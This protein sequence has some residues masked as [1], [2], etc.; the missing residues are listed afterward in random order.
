VKREKLIINRL[1]SEIYNEIQSTLNVSHFTFHTSLF[2]IL[3][4][5]YSG[6][7]AENSND[8][9]QKFL[10][11][12]ESMEATFIQS[13]INENGE[14]LEK[15][16][17]IL[18]L[19]QPGKFHWSYQIPYTQKIISNGDVLWIFDE[20]LEQIT[21]REMGDAIEQTPAGIILGN[22]PIN[23][24]FVQVNMGII[25][26]FDWIE[27]TPRD[28]EAQYRNIRLGFDQNRLGM[29]I[30]ADNLGQTTRIDFSNLKKNTEL[31]STL[32]YLEIPDNVDVIDER[33]MNNN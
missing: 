4:C 32:F 15:T 5:F 10:A 22:K 17:G 26:G 13:L 25:E 3:L 21:I 29:M 33:L 8:P 6:S 14:E 1:F 9:L 7:F 2:T 19:Q 24:H 31:S 30:I 16:E 23:E 11:N 12:F 27:L 18:Y 20:D 28:L